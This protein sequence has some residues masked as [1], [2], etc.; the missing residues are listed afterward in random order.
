[1]PVIFLAL[2]PLDNSP[3]LNGYTIPLVIHTL[4]DRFRPVSV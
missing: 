4:S 3:L 2:S 1:M